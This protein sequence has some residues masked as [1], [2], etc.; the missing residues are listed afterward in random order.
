MISLKISP[1]T[2]FVAHLPDEADNR[3]LIDYFNQFGFVAS[4]RVFCDQSTGRS[5]NFAMV[6]METAEGARKVQ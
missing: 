6:D 1:R 5:R 2:L 4:A 3:D